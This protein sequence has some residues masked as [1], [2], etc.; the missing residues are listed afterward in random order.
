MNKQKQKEQLPL[1]I[2]KI[3]LAI[4]VITGIGT[5]IFGGGYIIWKY[6]KKET[7]SDVSK[8]YDLNKK[9]KCEKS[10]GKWDAVICNHP[11]CKPVY[12]CNCIINNERNRD[13]GILKY[14][15]KF[16]L[17]EN[18]ICLSCK[19]DSDC[20]ENKCEMFESECEMDV[21]SCVDGICYA[22]N[23]TYE[24]YDNGD[25]IYNCVDNKCQILKNK[26]N[27][28]GWQIYRDEKF[29]FEFQY[30]AYLDIHKKDGEIK[31]SY[32][33]GDIIVTAPKKVGTEEAE[34]Y[35]CVNGGEKPTGTY[36]YDITSYECSKIQSKNG[37]DI[38]KVSY[39][40][41]HWNGSRKIYNLIKKIDDKSF[42]VVVINT[43]EMSA[44]GIASSLKIIK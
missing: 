27:T 12:F 33:H 35:K 21:A 6:N 16:R 5:I 43:Q 4:A 17:K 8:V 36:F 41:G 1:R 39:R 18:D 24:F 15:L 10:G 34:G 28:S 29:G 38:S 7:S 14:D 40:S 25:K 22:G 11:G 2:A 30:P 42:V 13:E 26:L 23:Y 9:E 32:G 3:T 44:D 19:Q 37:F 31:F 20:G